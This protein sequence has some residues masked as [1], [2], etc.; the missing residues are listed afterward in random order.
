MLL[1]RYLVIIVGI[2]L[3]WSVKA[4]ILLDENPYDFTVHGLADFRYLHADTRQ[5][6]VDQGLGKFRY[7]GDN[8]N[9]LFRVNEAALVVQARLSGDWVG[10]ITAKYGNRQKN[11]V[12]ISEAVLQFSP[13]STAAWRLSA[14]LGAFIPPISMENSGTAWSSP[15]T[16]TSSAINS[17]VGEELKIFGGEVQIGYQF[18]SG[19]RVN[20][21]GSGF[22]NNDTA[23]TLL[24][25]RGWSLHDYEATIND[26]LPLTNRTNI[27]QLFTRQAW[28]TQPFTEVDYRPGYYVGINLERPELIKFRALYYDNRA[29]TD[30]IDHG[31]YGWHTRFWSLGSKIELP[32]DIV[33]IGQG[34]IGR[35]QM[36]M[37]IGHLF[38]VDTGFWAESILLS[39][40][41]D[42]H[43]FSIRYDRFGTDEKDLLPQNANIERGYAWTLD[44][45]VTFFK[46]HQL[47]FEVSTVD[48]DR[49][50]RQLL[51]EATRQGETLWQFAYRLLF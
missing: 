12:D 50:D 47:N 38:P 45:N 19:D 44:Y 6:W 24:A 29:R 28:Q 18:A 42:L 43:R 27:H 39:K 8:A 23:G 7:G 34:M 11:P 14:R 20:V 36:G 48:S 31:Q 49:K 10:M 2:V 32:W 25:W 21:F 30:A 46:H 3:P 51:G 4:V 41:I 16:L 1:V 26:R 5:N 13:A 37:K 22:G 35:T 40:A 9:D 17:W 15:Y 33:L